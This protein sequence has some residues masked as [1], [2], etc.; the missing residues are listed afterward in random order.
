MWT[1]IPS[2]NPA[3]IA[4]YLSSLLA[5]ASDNVWAS[6]Y[7]ISNSGVYRTLVEH[8]DGGSWTIVPSPNAGAGDNAL[9]GI[10]GTQPNDIWAV[11]YGSLS[12]GSAAAT[13]CPPLR[14]HQLERCSQPESRWSATSSLEFRDCPG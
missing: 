1:I 14:W 10:A 11:G 12:L 7:Y 8:W 2:P 5:F 13:L 4:A 9:N 6:G 3:S